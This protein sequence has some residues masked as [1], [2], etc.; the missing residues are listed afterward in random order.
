MKYNY[1]EIYNLLFNDSE[2]IDKAH[3]CKGENVGFI[4]YLRGLIEMSNHCIK[5]CLYCGIRGSNSHSNRYTL[6]DKEIID[7]ARYA[8]NNQFGSIAIQAGERVSTDHIKRVTSLVTQIKELTNGELG[9]TLSLG[10]QKKETYQEWFRAGAERYLLRIETSNRDLYAK[11][12]PN[13]ALHSFDSRIEALHNLRDC[14]YQLGTG[15]MIGSPYQKREDLVSDLLF[16]Q[17]MDIDMCGMGPYLEHKETPLYS[18]RSELW[19]KQQR[20]DLTIGMIATLRLIMPKINIAATTALQ[21]I[22]P[23]GREKALWAGA[24]VIMP[25][26]TPTTTRSSYKLYEDK[27]INED[28]LDI[29]SKTLFER[30]EETGDTIGFNTKGNSLHWRRKL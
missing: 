23:L 2:L 9:I 27:P 10:E 22:D 1:D 25:N 16:M 4:T 3:R 30:I 19:S 8:Y 24:N 11:L 5:D 15:V 12:H 28:C 13:N 7:S 17:E 6:T 20:F 18:L 21:A 14:G 29:Q 26:I